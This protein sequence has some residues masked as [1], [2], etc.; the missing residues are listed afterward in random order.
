MFKKG[1]G[2][3]LVGANL[4]PLRP[5]TRNGVIAPVAI[6]RLWKHRCRT[7]ETQTRP[8]GHSADRAWLTA[9]RALADLTDDAYLDAK[10]LLQGLRSHAAVSRLKH[11][12]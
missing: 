1:R 5:H 11:C 8:F 7:L 9:F 3:M 10:Y 4:Q 12:L 6:R 2:T